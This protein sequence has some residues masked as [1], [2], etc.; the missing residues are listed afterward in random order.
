MSKRPSPKLHNRLEGLLAAVPEADPENGSNRGGPRAPFASGVPGGWLWEADL[1]GRYT[2]CSPE[3]ERF[4]GTRAADLLGQDVAGVG[5]SEESAAMVRPMMTSGRAVDGVRLEARGSDGSEIQLLFSA[6]LRPGLNGKPTG[7]RGAV[8]VL[9]ILPGGRPERATAEA[10]ASTSED[11]VAVSADKAPTP[12]P[13]APPVEPPIAA[14]PEEVRPAEPARA[15]PAAAELPAQAIE[16]APESPPFEAAPMPATPG[17]VEPEPAAERRVLDRPTRPMV[18]PQTLRRPTGLLA[19]QLAVTAAVSP[20]EV[21]PMESPPLLPAWGPTTAYLDTAAGIQPISAESGQLVSEPRIDGSRLLVPIKVKDEVLGVLAFDENEHGRSWN[22]DDITMAMGISEQLAVALQ[23]ARSVQLTEQALEEMR[24]ADRLKTQFLANMSHEL[25]TPLNSIIGFSRVILKGIDG[26][27]NETQEQDLTAIHHA[28]LHLLGLINDIL[29]LSKIEAGR[30]ELTF[31]DADLNEIVSGVMSTAAGLVKD[32][33]IE[34]ISHI[35][36]SLPF[37]QADSIRVRQILLNLVSNA[38][39]FTDQGQIE[40]SVTLVDDVEPPEVLMSVADTGPGIAAADQ[41][42]LFEPFSQVDASP[43]RKTGGTG[44]GLSICRHL[45]ELH[46]GTIW[47]ES[48]PGMGSAF[49]FTLP[50]HPPAETVS[51]E[52]EPAAPLVLAVDDDPAVLARYRELF[53]GLGFRFHGVAHTDGLAE[54]A[55]AT[56]ADL[57]V[58]DPMLPGY[59]GWNAVASLRAVRGLRHAPILMGGINTEKGHAFRIHASDHRL[60]PTDPE[61]LRDA[62]HRLVPGNRP[63]IQL[64]AIEDNESASE[65][66]QEALQAD[67]RLQ[68]RMATSSTEA[69]HATRSEIPDVVVL[70]L[71]MARAEGFRALEIMRKDNRLRGTP[72]LVLLSPEPHP[73]ER[74][75]MGL[76][77]DYIHRQGTASQDEFLAE[78][79]ILAR[80]LTRR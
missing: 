50:L 25:R 61:E 48:Q 39:K 57:I 74:R 15:R 3:V 76:Y 77:T 40:V 12:E 42:K 60:R 67:G 21:R 55:A 29:D 51:G 18:R 34:L 30:M 54:L 72:V 73:E 58:I 26:P 46:G 53:Q 38:A 19:S 37:I 47:V 27:V 33:P 36:D 75:Q 23:D 20:E 14:E 8:Q 7:Y 56:P 52:P 41:A 24:E 71:M 35:P 65:A 13:A 62:V 17:P 9:S 11:F 80:S 10:P 22:N 59:G 44:L 64:L 79:Q 28:G 32:K 43:T 69:Y 68:V 70:S 63:M 6:Q 45:V 2:W 31:G 49:F 78:L 4:L 5:L 16:V 1:Q 66:L